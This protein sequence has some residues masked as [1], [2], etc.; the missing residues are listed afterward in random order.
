MSD[1]RKSTNGFTIVELLIVI[2]VIAILAT[3]SVVVYSGVQARARTAKHKHEA[4]QIERQIITHALGQGNDNVSIASGSL[5]GVKEGAGQIDLLSPLIGSPNITM[6]S[7]YRVIGATETYNPY[8]TLQP[9]S[10]SGQI[11]H[12]MPGGAGSNAMVTRLDSSL[13]TN[14]TAWTPSGYYVAGNTV[15]CWVRVSNADPSLSMAC[16]QGAAHD[17]SPYNPAHAGWNFTKL[18]LR[19]NSDEIKSGLIFNVDHDQPTRSAVVNWLAE[20][21]NVSL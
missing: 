17:T 9:A 18:D 8:I 19:D 13:V 7:V 11:V 4:S 5:I 15:I 10:Y 14:E 21:Y 16:N 2:I 6:Y 3:I 12:L 1:M 20:E